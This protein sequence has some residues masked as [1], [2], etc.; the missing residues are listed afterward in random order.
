[1]IVDVWLAGKSLVGGRVFKRVIYLESQLNY[2]G[3][4]KHA[5]SLMPP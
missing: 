1:M 2:V 4:T 3:G 5:A